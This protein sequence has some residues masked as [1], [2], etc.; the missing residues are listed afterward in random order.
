MRR[1]GQTLDQ[2][3]LIEWCRD[4][5]AGYKCPRSVIFITPEQMPRN[6]M[7]KIERV[8]LKQLCAEWRLD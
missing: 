5:L 8:K 2:A 1:D 4:K 3:Q 7:N 6:A